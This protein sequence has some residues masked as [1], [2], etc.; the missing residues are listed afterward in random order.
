MNEKEYQLDLEKLM[1]FPKKGIFSMVVSKGKNH[2]HTLMCLSKGTDID[3]HTSTKQGMIIILKGK[4]EFLLYNE[5]I[6]MKKGIVIN[7]PKNAPHSLRAEE[8]LAMILCLNE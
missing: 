6:K 1:K 8:N 2:N 4:G 3:T 5:R 7:M